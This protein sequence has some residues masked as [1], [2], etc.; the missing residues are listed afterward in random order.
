[1]VR[2]A[3]I[4]TNAISPAATKSAFSLINNASLSTYRFL[5]SLLMLVLI[6]DNYFVDVLSHHE[7]PRFLLT[8][9]SHPQRLMF[10][11]VVRLARDLTVSLLVVVGV[12]LRSDPALA[13][14]RWREGFQL[15]SMYVAYVL[16]H[17]GL[18]SP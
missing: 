14:A 11:R 7:A 1:M 4:D 5:P 15:R 13:E 12:L 6:L 2:A 10:R 9:G 18:L 8:L 17:F 16:G 3:T